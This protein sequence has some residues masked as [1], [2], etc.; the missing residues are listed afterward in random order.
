[1]H[2]NKAENV[3]GDY[4]KHLSKLILEKITY[5][6]ISRSMHRNVSSIVS[7]KKTISMLIDKSITEEDTALSSESEEDNIKILLKEM[8]L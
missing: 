5:A 6:E 2:E 7:S 1:M 3:S 4:K 8:Y